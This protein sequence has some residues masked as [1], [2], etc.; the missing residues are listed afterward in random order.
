[1]VVK[2]INPIIAKTSTDLNI[3]SKKVEEVVKYLFTLIRK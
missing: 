3:D 2:N 1:M